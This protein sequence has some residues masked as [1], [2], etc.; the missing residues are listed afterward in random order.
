MQM[1]ADTNAQVVISP[2]PDDA[3]WS[4]GGR[5]AG[6]SEEGRQTTVVTVFD[7]PGNSS[8]KLEH[9]W[10]LAAEPSVRR[11]ED[12][13]A[14]GPLGCRTVS[15]GLTDAALR[16]SGATYRYGSPRRLFGE[17][18]ADDVALVS[19]IATALR[20][21]IQPGVTVHAPLAA[22]R[23]CDHALVRAAVAELAPPD[24]LWYEEFPYR[25]RSR[26]HVG[27]TPKWRKI[28]AAQLQIWLACGARYESQV[29]AMFGEAAR[30]RAALT[31]R[32]TEHAKETQS[33]Y[34]DRYWWSG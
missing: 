6:W 17:W 30:F 32:A 8:S 34:A 2:H 21:E 7:G 3:V 9:A 27:L 33:L 20:P 19:Q 26:D 11:R 10:R 13:A 12:R 15:L 14:L 4:V 18:H 5:L 25:L 31:T 23:H 28:E 1:S 29:T 22:G 16:R 24:L